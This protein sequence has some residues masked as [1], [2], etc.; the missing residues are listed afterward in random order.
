MTDKK[1]L[2]LKTWKTVIN[3]PHPQGPGRSRKLVPVMTIN[4][5]N[6]VDLRENIDQILWKIDVDVRDEMT[7]VKDWTFPPG[8]RSEVITAG[9]E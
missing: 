1:M 7:I 8:N 2:Q 4:L 5:I 6:Q 9:I 3:C